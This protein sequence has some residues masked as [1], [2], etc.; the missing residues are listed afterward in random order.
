MATDRQLEYADFLLEKHEEAGTLEDVIHDI[1]PDFKENEDIKDWFERL[2]VKE[3]SDVITALKE[4][5]KD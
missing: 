1:N 4:A 5:L 3:M 2:S